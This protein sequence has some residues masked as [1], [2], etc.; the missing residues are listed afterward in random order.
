MSNSRA[1]NSLKLRMQTARFNSSVIDL[2]YFKEMPDNLISYLLRLDNNSFYNYI[3]FITLLNEKHLLI[4]NS[5]EIIRLSNIFIS[6]MQS[7]S[8]KTLMLLLIN[9]NLLEHKQLMEFS[10]ILLQIT[11]KDKLKAI[12]DILVSSYLYNL[13]IVSI[14]SFIK[15]VRNRYQ[16]ESLVKIIENPEI[17]NNKNYGAFV[18]LILKNSQNKNLLLIA[19][20]LN[21]SDFL[22]YSKSLN[23]LRTYLLKAKTNEQAELIYDVITNKSMVRSFYL[24]K[25]LGTILR[26][27]TKEYLPYLKIIIAEK[28]Y[29]SD[30]TFDNIL[31][32]LFKATSKVQMEM[33]IDLL[34]YPELVDKE[35]DL[36][37]LLEVTLK[38][39]NNFTRT[40]I[41]RFIEKTIRSENFDFL[42]FNNITLID[43]ILKST[44]NYQ[45][46]CIANISDY[47]LDFKYVGSLV[48]EIL[49]IQ[50][51]VL[52]H[53]ITILLTTTNI[54]ELPDFFE[55]IKELKN[56]K[57][58]YQMKAIVAIL[59]QEKVIESKRY[60]QFMNLINKGKQD[61]VESILKIISNTNNLL[62]SVLK[63]FFED[64]IME[65]DF[66]KLDLMTIIILNY[67]YLGI[68]KAKELILKLKN[69]TKKDYKE[70]ISQI[71]NELESI[72]YGHS[73]QVGG[74]PNNNKRVKNKTKIYES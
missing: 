2:H 29:L 31:T 71:K 4:G 60:L 72:S 26:N 46:L 36:Y 51:P 59:M 64:I 30:C 66:D 7:L 21:D 43:G 74:I 19:K 20:A 53:Y 5:E 12:Y 3:F 44:E 38:I 28:R 18:E 42:D 69:T 56:C 23:L 63:E 65:F 67:S 50:D 73:Y 16:L 40:A 61:Q 47:I 68:E 57:N 1:L 39:N 58:E 14:V 9:T 17:R 54:K 35:D 32:T 49:S 8:T 52:I 13:N 25:V 22:G 41:N 48:E 34:E 6:K 15:E 33:T 37:Y 55:I 24:E 10:S 27:D 62:D 11:A 70:T 45:A